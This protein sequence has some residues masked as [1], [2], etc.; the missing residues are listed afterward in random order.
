DEAR[1]LGQAG[2]PPV[3]ARDVANVCDTTEGQQVVFAQREQLDVTYEGQLLVA[4]LE[5]GGEHVGRVDPQAGEELRI[6]PGHPRG[7]T[8]QA[9]AVGILPERDQDLPDG[10]LDARQV[11][12]VGDRAAGQLAV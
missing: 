6:G 11:D 5:G 9:V 7:R 1:K 4:G 3:H 12:G 10:A 2:D 8:P